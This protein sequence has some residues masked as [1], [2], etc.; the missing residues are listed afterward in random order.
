MHPIYRRHYEIRL[1][2]ENGEPRL[3]TLHRTFWR[4]E[5]GQYAFQDAHHVPRGRPQITRWWPRDRRPVRVAGR[6]L[7]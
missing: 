7:K 5:L 4:H 2:A 3:I 1:S 6:P